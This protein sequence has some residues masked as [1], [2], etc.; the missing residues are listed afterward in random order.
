LIAAGALALSL[1]SIAAEATR[2]TPPPIPSF[3]QLAPL[4]SVQAAAQAAQIALDG[5]AP[6]VEQA[7]M[8]EGDT[9]TA[10]VSLTSGTRLQQ[11]LI[12]LTAVQPTEKEKQQ[13]G[14]A[15][16]FYS[17]SGHELRFESESA[18]LAIQS[19]GP[20]TQADAGRKASTAPAVKRART[21]VAAD[22]LALG[23]DRPPAMSERTKKKRAEDPSL[24]SGGLEIGMKPFPPDVIERARVATEAVGITEADERALVGSL[25]ALIEFFQIAS[26]TSGLQ[27]VVMSVID[28][29]W[30]SIIRSGGKMPGLNLELLENQP[31][32]E[33]KP[34]ALPTPSDSRDHNGAVSS[35]H[36]PG[37]RNRTPSE[38]SATSAPLPRRDFLKNTLAGAVGLH[39]T[40]RRGFGQSL[41][42]LV[43]FGWHA[44]AW[45]ERSSSRSVGIAPIGCGWRITQ[46]MPGRSFIRNVPHSPPRPP[47]FGRGCSTH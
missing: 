26:K 2:N 29:P 37:I 15:M 40:A 27:K 44:S 11:W 16:V 46:P 10:L 41:S 19:I 21:R 47:H 18:A 3:R 12:A 35:R 28:V 8:S 9:V 20:L 24:P 13:R 14:Q 5:I 39:L 6:P 22:F 23:L 32:I 7:N 30:W 25:L 38:M 45:R 1:R 31:R 43:A 36:S 42:A 17:S 4:A 34:W 33:A